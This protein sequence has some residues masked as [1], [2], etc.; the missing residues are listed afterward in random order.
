MLAPEHFQHFPRGPHTA[1][2]HILTALTDSLACIN[3]RGSVKQ[4]LIGFG[5]PAR[6]PRPFR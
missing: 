4:A 3:L 6:P 1:L 5:N 2:L